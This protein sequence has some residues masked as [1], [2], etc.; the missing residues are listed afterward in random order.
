MKEFIVPVSDKG[1]IA[2]CCGSLKLSQLVR[3][4]DCKKS[5]PS[6]E[7]FVICTAPCNQ[8]AHVTYKPIDWYCPEG[9]RKD[10]DSE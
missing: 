7:K 8:M 9:E 3:C 5:I 1:N 2:F 6:S 10:S 4:K